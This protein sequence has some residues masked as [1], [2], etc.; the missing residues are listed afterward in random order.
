MTNSWK[1][2]EWNTLTYVKNNW[3]LTLFTWIPGQ[4][5]V[6]FTSSPRQRCPFRDCH[7]Y[8]GTVGHRIEYSNNKNTTII[9]Y[10]FVKGFIRFHDTSSSDICS[11]DSCSSNICSSDICSSETLVR[12]TLVRLRHLFVW[13]ICS[14][15]TCSSDTLQPGAFQAFLVVGDIFGDTL[16]V[17]TLYYTFPVLSRDTFFS[18]FRSQQTKCS[19]CSI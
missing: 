1:S 17:K 19:S 14:S 15:D 12:P 10:P 6:P 8:S 18:D 13:D 2:W 16:L 5:N 9:F 7:D 4:F 3:T 11:S